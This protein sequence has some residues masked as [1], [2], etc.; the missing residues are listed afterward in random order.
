M[1]FF[2]SSTFSRSGFFNI[3]TPSS[4]TYDSDAQAYF[5]NIVANSGSIGTSAKSA[6]NTFV[7]GLKSDGLW[8]LCNEIGIFVGVDQLAGAVVKLK[9]G[10]GGTQPNLVATNLVS[11]D[12]VATGSTAGIKGN[13]SNKYL[14]TGL[15]PYALSYSTTNTHIAAY[16]TPTT[17][18]SFSILMGADTA[19]NQNSATYL[20]KNNGNEGGSIAS[21]NQV[22]LSGGKQGFCMV[23]TNNSTTQTY[24]VAGSSAGSGTQSIQSFPNVNLF[25]LARSRGTSPTPANPVDFSSRY[26]RGY[27][28]GTGMSSTQA[29][30]FSSRWQTLM[31]SFSA[32]V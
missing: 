29:S 25:L 27:S 7:Q 18:G 28:I 20:G 11:G 1:A 8:S 26:I 30:N 17:D 4:S 24:Y 3:I 2:S 5:N 22:I 12:Y 14:N 10:T 19:A 16:F 6:I 32:N 9:D 15:N 21:V 13:G 31:T 23:T